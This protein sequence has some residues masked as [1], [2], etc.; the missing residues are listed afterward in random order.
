M[1]NNTK[2]NIEKL[3]NYLKKRNEIN[4]DIVEVFRA[5]ALFNGVNNIKKTKD[6]MEA[7]SY[8]KP[9]KHMIFILFDGFGYEKLMSL[10]NNSILKQNLVRKIN[11]V[12]PT[13][14]ACVL[15]SL[16]SCKYPN[17][18]GIYGWWDYNKEFNIDY[19]PLLF[20]ERK[21]GIPLD[22]KGIKLSDIYKFEPIFD[23]FKTK[24]N[25]Y[26]NLD[27]INSYYTKM[28]TKNV[29]THG[30]RSIKDCFNKI[31]KN[32][33]SESISTFNYIYIDGLDLMSHMYGTDS[34]EVM[35]IIYEVEDGIKSVI[36]SNLDISFIVTADHGQVNMKSMLYLNQNYDYSKYF[37]ATPSIDTRTISFFVKPEYIEEFKEKF[38][39]E[40]KED[41]I[42]LTKEEV[43]T[44]NL[45]GK[46]KFSKIAK[47]SLGEFIAVIVNDKFM[48]CDKIEKE[49]KIFTKGNHS[50]LTYNET[51][52]PLIVI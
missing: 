16:I 29:S 9:K 44:L 50:G 18:H 32:L 26:E 24:V 31:I 5:I 48:V 4:V 36:N 33:K 12:N 13:S 28:F 38:L 20:E 35:N 22:K 10:D 37:Y 25:V 43:E 39:N 27:I 7:Y 34:K 6:V 19:F 51:V 40:F 14:T 15:T 30:Y 52:V 23:K 45:F 46:E 3:E 21:T 41:V 17:E 47:D 11:T 49:D 1:I 42:L 8:L 2:Q